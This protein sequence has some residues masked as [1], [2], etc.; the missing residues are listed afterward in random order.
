MKQL[1]DWKAKHLSAPGGATS[2]GGD[3]DDD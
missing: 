1:N 2:T 3:E